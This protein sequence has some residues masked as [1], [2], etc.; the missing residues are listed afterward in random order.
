LQSL[1]P[2]TLFD[3]SLRLGAIIIYQLIQAI[4]HA[5]A[6]PL[7]TS[8][9]KDDFVLKWIENSLI[10]MSI[11]QT[12]R[13]LHPVYKRLAKPKKVENPIEGESLGWLE[14]EKG[15][16]EGLEN[17]FRNT[18]G[19]SLFQELEYIRSASI[20]RDLHE[21]KH[22]ISESERIE[23]LWKEDPDDVKC[24]GKA[25]P[26][27]QGPEAFKKLG[28]ISDSKGDINIYSSGQDIQPIKKCT[29]CGRRI[30]MR[31]M[32]PIKCKP[33]RLFLLTNEFF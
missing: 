12:F 1:P 11:V 6:S 30:V 3:Y 20:P 17:I 19:S 4:R 29:G 13:H 14:L 21:Y 27:A 31:W 33:F 25:I 18:F 15:G 10:P 24:R 2:L 26:K 7:L 22:R 5:E 8:I 32:T 16:I 9:N 28:V 23:Q